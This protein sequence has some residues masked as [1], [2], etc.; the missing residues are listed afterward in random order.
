MTMTR[1][2]EHTHRHARI[3]VAYTGACGFWY[4]DWFIVGVPAAMS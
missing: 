1:H 3:G 2:T 4:G